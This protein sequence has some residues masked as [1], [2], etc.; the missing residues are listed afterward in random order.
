MIHGLIN[1]LLKIGETEI[2]GKPATYQ[3]IQ[4][5][6]H[7]ETEIFSIMQAIKPGL[8]NTLFK[9]FNKQIVSE[10]L[11]TLKGRK[12]IQKSKCEIDEKDHGAMKGTHFLLE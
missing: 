2:D 1:T 7:H 10:Y 12:V 5:I 6:R 8:F 9:K 11:V 3:T 4:K